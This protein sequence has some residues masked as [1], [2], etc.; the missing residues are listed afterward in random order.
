MVSLEEEEKGTY[1]EPCHG[2]IYQVVGRVM[3]A[4]TSWPEGPRGMVGA[5]WVTMEEQQEA[6]LSP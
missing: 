3:P 4:V 2:N 1:S 5:F 6:G